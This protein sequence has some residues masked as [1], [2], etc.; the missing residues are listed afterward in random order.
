M[1]NKY[2]NEFDSLK[3]INIDDIIAITILVIYYL[4]RDHLLEVY[5]EFTMIF[6]KAQLF[7]KNK[8]GYSY[9]NIIKKAGF[10]YIY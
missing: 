3:K 7:I 4:R 10:E 9:E 5:D 8:T 6:K 1:K 2:K